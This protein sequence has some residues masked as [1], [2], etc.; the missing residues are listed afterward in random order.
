MVASTCGLLALLLATPRL[1]AIDQKDL[2]ADYRAWLEEVDSIVTKEELAAF[3]KLEK[4][5]QRDAFIDRSWQE[6]DP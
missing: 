3:L 5:Y 2:P 4:D 6:R 1:P